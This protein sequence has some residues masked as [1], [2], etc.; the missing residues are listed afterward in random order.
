MLAFQLPGKRQG[1]QGQRLEASLQL[2][3]GGRL[4]D[5][6]AFSESERLTDLNCFKIILGVVPK[7]RGDKNGKT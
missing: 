3:I 5:G 6:Q 4:F 1:W 7:P 2:S